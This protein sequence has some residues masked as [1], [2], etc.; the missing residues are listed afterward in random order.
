ME[1]ITHNG[2]NFSRFQ[3]GTVQLG[4]DYG[5]G[6]HTQKPTEDYAFS[7]LDLALSRGVNTLDTANNYGDSQ[8]VIGAWLKTLPAEK[9]PFI[10]TKI[11]PFDHS[12]DAALRADIRRQTAGCLRDLGVDVLDMLM[13]HNFED[14]E[15][16]P[17]N[18]ARGFP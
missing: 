7:L 3:L 18:G 16:I 4:M 15:K 13:V 11:G 17:R 2:T 12:S 10:I 1:Y 8:K 6:D 14:F 5:L 9:R